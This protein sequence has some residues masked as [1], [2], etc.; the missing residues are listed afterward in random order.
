MNESK[1]IRF[2][3]YIAIILITLPACGLRDFDD[4][5][6][7]KVEN[8]SPSL[9][10]PLVKGELF[11]DQLINVGEEGLLEIDEDGLY[12]LSYAR[13]LRSPN[14]EQL[15]RVPNQNFRDNFNFPN[16]SSLPFELIV[17]EGQQLEASYSRD[18]NFD[19]GDEQR[20]ITR[21]II[22]SG[23]I[24]FRIASAVAH[25]V[26][27]F[28]NFNEMRRNEEP[29]LQIFRTTFPDVQRIERVADLSG[30]DINLSTNSLGGIDINNLPFDIR[31]VL[32]GSGNPISTEDFVEVEIFFENL[33]FEYIEGDMGVI[34]IPAF[35][36]GVDI[37]VF[38]ELADVDFRLN[39]SFFLEFRSA[40][41]LAF[42]AD[43]S[44][45]FLAYPEGREERISGDFFDQRLLL[46]YPRVTEVGQ[47]KTTER[48]INRD[49]SNII[50]GFFE[51]PN[52]V[53]F[54]IP[55]VLGDK[56]EDLNFLVDT[57]FIE[58]FT[59]VTIPF[60]GQI[61][62]L[63]LNRSFPLNQNLANIDEAERIELT[64]ELENGFPIELQL[65]GYLLGENGQ[66]LDSIFVDT[67]PFLSPAPVNVNGIVQSRAA[68][69]KVILLN[70]QKFEN[71]RN[72]RELRVEASLVTTNAEQQEVK[73]LNS[74]G[75]GLRMHVKGKLALDFN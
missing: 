53:D 6:V 8:P 23:T 26:D 12:S 72:A 1:M 11:L 34:N 7:V 2:L 58:L 20:L 64:I 4:F 75:L 63:K 52:R 14:A 18:I 69:T 65:Q 5:N 37:P 27:V 17:P 24:G 25:D 19:F 28:I 70:A 68:S 74:Y 40:I 59:Q 47:V 3:I 29:F 9:I 15:L 67:D 21:L 62:R 41:G 31:L 38:D 48:L 54:Q 46:D 66:L 56:T 71:L 10:L 43:L 50:D 51:G 55:M 32:T 16:L 42:S 30:V 39:P 57:S 73:I 36:G 49:N 22:K 61:R 35:V 45:M 44:S 60:E 33:A 13:S